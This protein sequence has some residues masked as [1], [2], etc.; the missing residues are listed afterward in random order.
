MRKKEERESLGFQSKII[1]CNILFLNL[2]NYWR[3]AA[4]GNCN[5]QN[6]ETEKQNQKKKKASHSFLVLHL[7]FISNCCFGFPK[8]SLWFFF[9]LYKK[10]RCFFGPV[11]CFCVSEWE[12]NFLLF[13]YILKSYLSVIHSL[14]NIRKPQE[15]KYYY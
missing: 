5:K 2:K 10:L 11:S 15:K 6:K 7:I 12:E 1:W 3:F 14:I 4:P 9:F 13:D 8:L